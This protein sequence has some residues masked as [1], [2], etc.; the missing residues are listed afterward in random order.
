MRPHIDL[1]TIETPSPHRSNQIRLLVD[2]TI[3]DL[4]PPTPVER[5]DAE[6][7]AVASSLA[8]GILVTDATNLES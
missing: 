3:L 7:H 6:L 1:S 2:R 4:L 5:S 8:Q